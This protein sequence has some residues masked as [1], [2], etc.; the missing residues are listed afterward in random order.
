MSF[1][2]ARCVPAKSKRHELQSTKTDKLRR[3]ANLQKTI[4]YPVV[5]SLYAGSISGAVGR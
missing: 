3:R 4:S 2:W 1:R 5:E